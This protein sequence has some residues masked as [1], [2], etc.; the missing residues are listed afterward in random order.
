MSHLGERVTSLVDGQLSVEFAERAL[1]H[2]A[3]CD[4]CREAVESERLMKQRLASLSALEPADFLVRRLLELASP[5]GPL[6]PRSGHVPGSPRPELVASLNS[7][8]A[9][10]NASWAA[11]PSRGSFSP[12]PGRRGPSRPPLTRA[13]RSAA[14]LTRM[15]RVGRSSRNRVAAAMV[16]AVCLVGA[17]V[18]GGVATGG[19]ASATTT[20]VVPPVDSLVIEHSATVSR[21]PLADQTVV[22]GVVGAQK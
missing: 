12:P 21:M 16:G 22:W 5:S 13:A 18:A 11:E 7:I 9:Q 10:S 3:G 8:A 4:E 20:R 15:A 19:A 2:V 17:G 1:M 14:G 6:P